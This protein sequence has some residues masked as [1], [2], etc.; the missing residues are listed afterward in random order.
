MDESKTVLYMYAALCIMLGLGLLY[1]R[2]LSAGISFLIV[3]A[4][5]IT[6][7]A[8]LPIQDAPK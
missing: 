2:I 7:V 4:S 5:L 8:Y 3:G 1:G 6:L